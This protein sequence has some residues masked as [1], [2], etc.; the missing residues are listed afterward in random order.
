MAYLIDWRPKKPM[1]ALVTTVHGV[2]TLVV[3]MNFRPTVIAKLFR[4]LWLAPWVR[5]P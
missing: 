1:M 5:I 3:D 2:V 4:Q